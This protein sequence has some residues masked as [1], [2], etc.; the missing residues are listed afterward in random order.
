[1]EISTNEPCHL[2]NWSQFWRQFR[3]FL[4]RWQTSILKSGFRN[5]KSTV[6]YL[7]MGRWPIT[8]RPTL[9]IR[10][11]AGGERQLCMDATHVV[12]LGRQWTHRLGSCQWLAI[13]S[14]RYRGRYSWKHCQGRFG[15]RYYRHAIPIILQCADS[16]LFMVLDKEQSTTGQDAFHRCS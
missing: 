3:R 2:W 13:L 9:A 1:M 4:S 16:L 7:Q 5:G 6:Q 12:S 8:W 10:H 11:T 14:T 15:G